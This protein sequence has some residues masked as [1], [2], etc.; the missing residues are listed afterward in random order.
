M[1]IVYHAKSIVPAEINNKEELSPYWSFNDT[2]D[3]S[4][5]EEFD[6][7]KF[8]EHELHLDV[9]DPANVDAQPPPVK[10][11]T[12]TVA[13]STP[14]PEPVIHVGTINVTVQLGNTALL[15]CEIANLSEKM[16]SWVRRRDWH[17][18]SSGVLTY[19][20]DGRFRVFHS[21][22]SDDWDLRISPVAKIDNGTYECQVGTG[23]GIMTHYFNLFVIV[24]T[25]VISGKD[26]YHI[27]EGSSITLYCSIENSPVPPQYVSWY[28]NGKIISSSPFNKNGLKIDRMSINTEQIDHKTHSRL[29]IT[30][31]IQIDTGNYT[32]Q[33]PN[34]DPDSIYIHIT[35]E[36]DNTAA[37]QRQKSSNSVLLTTE[38]LSIFPLWSF[39]L[40]GHN[41]FRWILL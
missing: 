9:S 41:E 16:V 36:F 25:A 19:I 30:K 2:A 3:I 5:Y 35:P 23:T 4:K 15:H 34:T 21:E 18:L 28:F 10:I 40:I 39:L 27:G 8:L 26:E 1:A 24:P 32:C 17:I 31:A 20:N 6:H 22:K 12:T 13:P 11:R 29:T 33:P 7:K 37:I 38:L 14:T